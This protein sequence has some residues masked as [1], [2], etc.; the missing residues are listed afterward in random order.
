MLPMN[1]P[2]NVHHNNHHDGVMTIMHRDEEVS[3][4]TSWDGLST[5][6][7]WLTHAWHG[8]VI[9]ACQKGFARPAC[10]IRCFLANKDSDACHL[11]S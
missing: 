6:I 10:S 2:K 8:A 11:D 5:L 7:Y 1:A 4:L 9:V 3:H